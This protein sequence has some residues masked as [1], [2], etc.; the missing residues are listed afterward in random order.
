[1]KKICLLLSIWSFGLWSCGRDFHSIALKFKN[2]SWKIHSLIWVFG[3]F[4]KRF[5]VL[6]K[7]FTVVNKF[8]CFARRKYQAYRFGLCAVLW[9]SLQDR[10]WFNKRL[11]G[12]RIGR[13][14]F[15]WNNSNSSRWWSRRFIFQYAA[16]GCG[17]TSRCCF[18]AERPGD[19]MIISI[20]WVFQN[21]GSGRLTFI[22]VGWDTGGGRDKGRFMAFE[23]GSNFGWIGW[24]C[25]LDHWS[26]FFG[27][28]RW[29]EDGLRG[30]RWPV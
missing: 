25:I 21:G 6:K 15:W 29:F 3:P 28:S 4:L 22:T 30:R 26:F 2:S 14:R 5:N 9:L 7:S 19:W 12:G 17:I 20:C 13:L 27:I 18:R 16:G 8:D 23:D 24:V 1:M 11:I 10:S